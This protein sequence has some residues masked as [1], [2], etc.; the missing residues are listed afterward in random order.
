MAGN[1]A[2]FKRANVLMKQG[3]DRKQAFAI[4]YDESGKTAKKAVKKN[5]VKRAEWN[6]FSGTGTKRSYQLITDHLPGGRSMFTIDPV[7]DS[8]GR[9]IAYS[10]KDFGI[11]ENAW[12]IHKNFDRIVNAK[13]FVASLLAGTVKKNPAKRS[14]KRKTRAV[15]QKAA[16]SYVN[17]PSQITKK[18]PTKRLR[19]R[20][21]KNLRVP[22]GVFP[23]PSKSRNEVV[24]VIQVLKGRKLVGFLTMSGKVTAEF[25]DAWQFPTKKD[26]EYHAK[27]AY[28]KHAG[29]GYDFQTEEVTF[30]YNN[31]IAEKTTKREKR[32]LFEQPEFPFRVESSVDGNKWRAEGSFR[33]EIIA[34]EYARALDRKNGGRVW[35]RVT[36]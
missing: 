32:G 19:V 27:K 6:E 30:F 18:S 14:V 28:E 13:K 31:P 4:A 35:I 15:T 17:R 10:V 22:V 16:V 23:N 34:R 5:P 9:F 36:E 11:T 26:A 25:P 1:S 7:Y 29:K 8:R 3:H 21:T 12:T 33:T 20:R 24:F 2:I